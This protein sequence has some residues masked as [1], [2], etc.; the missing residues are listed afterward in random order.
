[1]FKSQ[2]HSLWLGICQRSQA[3]LPL[4]AFQHYLIL[5]RPN[6]SSNALQ[7][8]RT[9]TEHRKEKDMERIAA[10]RFNKGENGGT[11]RDRNM[12]ERDSSHVDLFE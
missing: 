2:L 9:E 3:A 5:T 11:E 1:M 4:S 7:A 12:E 10:S 6:R 8:G